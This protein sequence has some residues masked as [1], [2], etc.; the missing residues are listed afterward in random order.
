VD[1]GSIPSASTILRGKNMNK[2]LFHR[3]IRWALGIHGSIHIVETILNIYEQ[4]YMSALLSLLAGLL[5]IAG[6]CIDSDHHKN[7]DDE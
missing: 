6:A 3:F 4:A 2:S 5:M 1:E 7:K